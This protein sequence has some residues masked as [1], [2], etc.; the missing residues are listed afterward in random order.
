M[1]PG[2]ELCHTDPAHL[3]TVGEGLD[4]LLTDHDLSEV[5]S[6]A[7]GRQKTGKLYRSARLE[8]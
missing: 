7:V 8:L 2:L 4:D 1:F 5:C 3:I 6:A